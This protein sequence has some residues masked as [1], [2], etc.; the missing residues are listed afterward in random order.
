MT[1]SWRRWVGALALVPCLRA[2]AQGAPRLSPA[3]IAVIDSTA[4]S[5]LAVSGVPSASLAVVVGGR[6]AYLH[7]YGRARLDPDVNARPDMRYAV[8]SISKQFAATAVLLLAQ[9]GKLSLDDP[10]GRFLPTLT[11]AS[12]VTIREV[13]SHTSGYEDYWPQDY[14]MP[15]MLEATTADRV[16]TDWARKPLDF[17][18]GTRWQYSNTNYVVVGRIVEIASGMPFMRFLQERIFT[19]LSMRSVADID[20]SRLGETDAVGYYRHAL[21]PPRAAPKE[22]R[23]WLF[24]AGELAMPAADLARWD[25]ALLDRQLL[26]PASYA[27]FVR[28]VH[29]KDGTDTHY[30]LGLDIG[31]LEGHRYWEHSGEVSGFV[32]EN[33][34]LP[35]DSAAVAVLTNMD[36]SSA[37][38][39]IAHAA[40]DRILRDRPA[41][42]AAALTA[43]ESQALSILLGLER[44]QI[45]RQRFTPNANAYFDAQAIGD[46]AS[47]LAPFGSPRQFCET[48]EEERGGMTFRA[49]AATFT[50]RVLIITTYTLP[51]GRLE[52]YL[53]QPGSDPSHCRS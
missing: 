27:E 21:G 33:I 40:V 35:D 41:P 34:V 44:G 22:G 6:V 50:D 25:I 19:P 16:L 49:F 11:R 13:L 18:P 32:A 14:V 15:S 51:D 28:P 36:A 1:L 20:T 3:D 23:G 7:A 39:V 29:L 2:V 30:A 5:A 8:G 43:P 4:R 12:E 48:G 17:D 46:Y 52:Q 47:S 45:D 31:A 26:S 37:A 24:A 10:V 9:D 53:V 38:A 42:A